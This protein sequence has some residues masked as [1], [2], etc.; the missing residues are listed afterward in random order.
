MLSSR[1]ATPSAGDP[2]SFMAYNWIQRVDLH[3][4]HAGVTEHLVARHHCE[5]LFHHA[6]G[7]RVA[8]MPRR[9]DAAAPSAPSSP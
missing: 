5:D 8:I 2:L 3:E 6:V 7:A 9:I 1:V 4:L